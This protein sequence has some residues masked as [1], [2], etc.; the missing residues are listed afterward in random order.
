M[1]PVRFCTINSWLN[2]REVCINGMEAGGIIVILG[3]GARI[4]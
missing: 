2:S 3:R 1:Q 4:Y